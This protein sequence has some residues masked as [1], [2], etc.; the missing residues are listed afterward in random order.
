DF[1]RALDGSFPYAYHVERAFFD[2]AIANRAAEL[3]AVI[4]YGSS[5]GGWSESG[6]GV[7]LVGDW[8][9]CKARVMVDATG[10]QAI[11]GRKHRT[12]QPLER[13]GRCASF[14]TF[15]AV[16]SAAARSHLGAGDIVIVLGAAGWSWLIPLPGD[17]VSVGLVER[18]PV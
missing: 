13:F 12:I 18:K 9:M 17:R 4:L 2:H 6:E 1:S 5:V 3:G 16:T 11:V 14:T 10:H 7:E 15:G 8:G